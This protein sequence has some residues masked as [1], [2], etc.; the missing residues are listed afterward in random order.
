MAGWRLK[1]SFAST[2]QHS[3]PKELFDA[4]LD[5]C[6][7]IALRDNCRSTKWWT[8]GPRLV[9]LAVTTARPLTPMP[10]ARQRHAAVLNDGGM[11]LHLAIGSSQRVFAAGLR[12]SIGSGM[13]CGKPDDFSA[14]GLQSQLNGTNHVFRVVR[15]VLA[16][17]RPT[18]LSDV[19]TRAVPDGALFAND[20][21][22]CYCLRA[23]QDVDLDGAGELSEHR[24]SGGGQI[25]AAAAGGHV[26]FPCSSCQKAWIPGWGR[27]QAKRCGAGG[28][29]SLSAGVAPQRRFAGG[30]DAA[31]SEPARHYLV[32]TTWR[33][34]QPREPRLIDK[35]RIGVDWR[36]PYSTLATL[37]NDSE[38]IAK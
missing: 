10:A 33:K 25:P 14:P 38:K 4:V 36:P 30:N 13:L 28:L 37:R 22:G 19:V 12:L 34:A 35:T 11:Q 24:A 32:W 20:P 26:A 7:R 5:T 27:R 16:D 1:T 15:R 23:K 31:V 6:R 29:N 2:L 3:Q 9:T 17:R 18:Q 21:L 8:A